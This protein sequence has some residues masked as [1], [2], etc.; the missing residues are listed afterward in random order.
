VDNIILVQ[1]ALHSRIHRKDKGMIIKLDMA[2]AFDRFRHNFLFKVME[3]FVFTP[4]FINW[5]KSCIGSPR[6]APLVNGQ[7]TKFFQASRGLRQGCPLSLLLYAIQASILSFQLDHD[8]MHNNLL[9]LRITLGV[10]DINH[11]Q[12]SYDM[13]LMG[14]ASMHT[15]NKFKKELYTH[16]EVLGSVISLTKSKI[17]GWNITPRDMLDISRVL[18][19]EGCT[20][21]DVFKYLGVPF[22]KSNTKASHLDQLIE[23][24]KKE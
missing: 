17:F 16:T 14:G 22:F 5:I 15:K 20:T 2:N 13:L 8:Q 3:N 4:S 18:G 11:A 12:F 9:D 6:I 24:L 21:W 1:E 10:K 23:K 19:M 7:A